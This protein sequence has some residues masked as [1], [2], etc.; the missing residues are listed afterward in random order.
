[1]LLENIGLGKMNQRNGR[2]EYNVHY[3]SQCLKITKNVSFLTAQ[4]LVSTVRLFLMIFKN[5]ALLPP[6]TTSQFWWGEQKT[7]FGSTSKI[8]SGNTLEE[9]FFLIKSAGFVVL[10]LSK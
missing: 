8:E 6:R 1:M 10:L 9:E 4:N 2:N 5:C 3:Y 7:F